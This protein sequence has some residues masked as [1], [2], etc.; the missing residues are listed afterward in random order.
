MA[1]DRAPDGYVQHHPMEGLQK[2]D[3]VGGSGVMLRREVI[4][5]LG[6][7][8]YMD[9]YTDGLLT[10]SEDFYLSRRLVEA[11]YEIWTDFSL[12]QWHKGVR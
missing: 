3:A 8:W 7:P 1:L 4:E 11:G 9:E 12:V 2:V 5:R 10:L 6:S